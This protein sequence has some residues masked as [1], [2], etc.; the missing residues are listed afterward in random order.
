VGVG[1]PASLV[2]LSN[3]SHS[4]PKFEALKEHQIF[5]N[6]VAFTMS[7]LP[8]EVNGNLQRTQVMLASGDYFNS[9]NVR[10][11]LG[12]I[13]T[14]EDDRI[15]A[16]VA[17]LSHDFWTRAFAAAPNVLGKSLRVNGMP[18]TI[19]GV[20]SPEF[21]GVVVGAA[22]D[23]TLPVTTA[24]KILP[25]LR[26]DVLTR[27]SAHWLNIMARLAPGQSLEQANARLQVVWPQVLAATAPPGESP[28]SSYFQHRT[29]LH[30]AGNGFSELR[31]DYSTPL[32]M[33]MVL[34]GI[35]LLIACANVSNL[36]LARGSARRREFA[37]RLATGA[38]RRRLIC[39]LLTENM[40]LAVVAA[41]AGVLFASW[42]VRLLVSFIASGQNLL[43]LDLHP[44]RRVLM[45]T[46]GVTILTTLLFGLTPALRGIRLDVI[47]SLK[48]STQS[49][50]GSGSRLIKGLITA[51]VALSMALT[52]GAGLFIN[53]LR[54]ILN[55]DIGFE[56]TNVLLVRADATGGGHRGPTVAQFYTTISGRLN[57]LPG[58]QSAAMSWAPPVSRGFGNNGNISIEGHTPRREEDSVVWSNFVSPRYFETIGQRMLAGREFTERDREGAPKV[59][60]INQSM[61]RYFFGD[62]NPIGKKIDPRGGNNYECEIV[63]V[64]RDAAHMSLKDLPQ[65]VFYVPYA[66]SPTFVLNESMTLYVHTTAP[67]ASIARQIREEVAQLDKNVFVDVETLKSYVDGSITRERLLAL[68][69]GILGALSLLLV[70]IGLYGVM[71]YSVTRRTVEIGIRIALGARPIDVLW[72]VLREGFLLVLAG[73]AIGLVVVWIS[74]SVIAALLFGITTRDATTFAGAVSI[75]AMV[76]L[77]ATLLPARRAAR[78]DPMNALRNE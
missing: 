39:Q 63:G 45:F 30:P 23:I 73:V 76:A 44:D 3:G 37:V 47:P 70:A 34:V 74:S 78:I 36:L 28:N 50:S 68:L 15:Q 16:P 56:T 60:I 33:L 4:Y 55:V 9:L 25:E 21:T 75:M 67:S 1:E 52:V 69:S 17:V 51:Q 18:V 32:Y 48:E 38:T 53:S 20:T 43:F 65:R 40:L 46:I 59:A 2:R 29:E 35:V 12:R 71:A 77:L 19:V 8:A 49:F 5:A 41:L 64:V 11:I 10:V 61:A 66:Q 72:M 7:T 57:S 62:E 54:N 14:P 27:R 42:G 6:T 24:P 22:T 31:A 26:S 58:V 13:L